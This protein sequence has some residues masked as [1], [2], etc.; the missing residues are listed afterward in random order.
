M[1]V[2]LAQQSPL[3]GTDYF[4]LVLDKHYRAYGTL[5]NVSRIVIELS[6]KLELTH[7]QQ[8]VNSLEIFNWMQH[9][10]MMRSSI[11]SIPFW[12]SISNNELISIREHFSEAI[13][14]SV[15]GRDLQP[16]SGNLFF[17]DLIQTP[18]AKSIL[19]F[20]VHHSLMDSKGV[21][22][23][24]Q[25]LA[26]TAIDEA[27]LNYFPDENRGDYSLYFKLKKSFEAKHFVESFNF[28][29]MATLLRSTPK[30]KHHSSYHFI[31]FTPD[32]ANIID[33][34][35]KLNGSVFGNSLFY[36][37]CISRAINTILEKRGT[38]VGDFWIPV[39]QN[40]RRRG[41]DGT[42]LSNQI[43]F[44]FFR[45]AQNKLGSIKA[46]T[47]DLSNQMKQ[48]IAA[49]F[50]QTYSI[51][52]ELFRRV[53]LPFYSFLIKNASKGA[54]ASYSFSDIGESWEGTDTFME[55]PLQRVSHLP[56]NPY[57]PGFTVV[58]S[59]YKGALKFTLAYIDEAI[60]LSEV[61]VFEQ[62]LRN[63]LLQISTK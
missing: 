32:E 9:L 33:K 17:F 42:L 59:K 37:S 15:L 6:S 29:K 41:G 13:P 58:V 25:L 46:C 47:A 44:M 35:S 36:L 21:K 53:P 23:L 3:S 52:M 8:R 63:D 49:S 34:N 4:Q 12:K 27:K 56:A 48:Q 51:M 28:K 39:P 11:W 18:E 19:V 5:G 22:L 16:N 57:I 55:I 50:P 62:F 54:T 24:M 43:S 2:N 61:Q 38:G 30:L 14:E 60:T 31:E 1:P 26:N 10:K 7:L 40:Q 20:S 45:L